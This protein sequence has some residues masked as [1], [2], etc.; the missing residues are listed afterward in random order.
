VL[1]GDQHCG[2]RLGLCPP[3][4]V[5]LD[6]GGRYEQSAAQKVVWSWW[7]EFWDKYVPAVA[8][9][10]KLVVVLGGDLIEGVHHRATTP[11][12]HNIGDQTALAEEVLA[13]VAKRATGGLYVVRG[14]EA[15]VGSSATDEEKLARQLGAIPNEAGQSARYDLR[16]KLGPWVLH[17]LHHVGAGCGVSTSPGH[18]ARELAD[19]YAAA[20]Q[21]GTTAPDIIVRHHVHRMAEVRVATARGLGV[22]CSVPAWQLKTPFT[23]RIR[24]GRVEPPQIGGLVVTYDQDEFKTHWYVRTIGPSQSVIA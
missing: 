3:G 2:C 24:G 6:D 14:T 16:L 4:G 21:W 11:I 8:G 20:S 15:H 23:W 22:A 12:S 1:V 13:P 10:G 5:P 19:E 9:R 7:R 18:L 17:D